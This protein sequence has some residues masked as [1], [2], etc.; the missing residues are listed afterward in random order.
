MHDLLLDKVKGLDMLADDVLGERLR[1]AVDILIKSLIDTWYIAPR[2][3]IVMFVSFYGAQVLMEAGLFKRLEFIGRPLVRLANLPSEAGTAFMISFG[4]VLAANTIIAKLHQERR[5]ER[6]E[7]VLSALLNTTPVYLKE[8]FTYQI[9]VIWPLLG[10]KVG[11]IYLLSFIA[12]GMAKIVFIIVYGRAQLKGAKPG[13]FPEFG[14]RVRR[15][16]SGKGLPDILVSSLKRE[17]KTFLK[18]GTIF[19]LTTF[20]VFLFINS[21]VITGLAGYIG[22]VTRFFNLPPSCIIPVGTYMFSPLVGASSIGAMLKKG[23]LTDLQGIIACLLGGFLMLPVFSLRHSLARYT[24]IFGIR[25]GTII[26]SIS[27]GLGMLTRGVFLLLF[28]M[29]S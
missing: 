21:N 2:V 7:A 5:I 18:V 22:P 24:S 3:L 1:N 8:T 25:L 15:I 16:K 6:S 14:S 19:V 26:L 23:M 12:T 10:L 28:L 11:F 27:T 17:G 13:E 29:M 20:I 9:P 4:S